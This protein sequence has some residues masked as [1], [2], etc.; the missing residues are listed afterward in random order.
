MTSP[1]AV[2]QR[3]L[4][5]ALVDQVAASTTATTNQV[6]VLAERLAEFKEAGTSEVQ[7]KNATKLIKENVPSANIRLF[8][9]NLRFVLEGQTAFIREDTVTPVTDLKRQKD[10][11]ASSSSLLVHCRAVE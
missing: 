9:N 1:L 10:I 5:N 7:L 6:A 8:L 11:I 4:I 2:A 3:E